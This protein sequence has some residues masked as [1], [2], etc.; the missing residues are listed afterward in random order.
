MRVRRGGRKDLSCDVD[1]GCGEPGLP[2]APVGNFQ[3][4]ELAVRGCNA[5]HD[6]FGSI[7]RDQGGI[8]GVGRIQ[9]RKS[10][11]RR[12]P[13]CRFQR[14]RRKGGKDLRGIVVVART[15][16]DA[17]IGEDELFKARFVVL[18]PQRRGVQQSSL[19]HGCRR[20]GTGSPPH[21]ATSLPLNVF[22][23]FLPLVPTACLRSTTNE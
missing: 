20:L 21:P 18:P 1:V 5:L 7:R 9:T 13:R 17:E 14:S 16:G 12:R 2:L 8:S 6:V 3:V 11:H 22:L 19:G 4:V 23:L 15:G 10:L